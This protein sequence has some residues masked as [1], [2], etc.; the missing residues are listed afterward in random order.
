MT[1]SGGSELLLLCVSRARVVDVT[2]WVSVLVAS[3]TPELNEDSWLQ[4]VCNASH[5]IP[6]EPFSIMT[7]ISK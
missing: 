5:L 6:L 7:N 2:G 4:R 1:S 3:G